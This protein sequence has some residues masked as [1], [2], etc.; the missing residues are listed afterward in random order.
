LGSARDYKA[1]AD[2]LDQFAQLAIL[3]SKKIVSTNQ[4]NPVKFL[5]VLRDLFTSCDQVV[6]FQMSF[7]PGE[8]VF[9][10]PAKLVD[11]GDLLG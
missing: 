2:A 11:G 6:D 9:D 3:P 7:P 1:E 8:R 5:R 4:Q 10:I